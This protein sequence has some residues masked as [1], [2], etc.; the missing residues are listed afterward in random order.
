MLDKQGAGR[1]WLALIAASIAAAS[2]AVV[3]A[4]PPVSAHTPPPNDGFR[5]AT[6][7][8]PP[9][10][11]PGP[12]APVDKQEAAARAQRAKQEQD[13]LDA[14]RTHAAQ[15]PPPLAE[16]AG[17]QVSPAVAKLLGPGLGLPVGS[18]LLTGLRPDPTGG[19]LRAR[20]GTGPQLT[21]AV[22]AGVRP[23]SFP[24]S[25]LVVDPASDTLTLTAS[26]EQAAV[27]VR[28]AHA[29]KTTLTDEHDL[30][31]QVTLS[32]AVLGATV[33]LSGQLTYSGGAPGVSLTGTLADPVVL[34]R[35]VAVLDKGAQVGL[36]STELRLS[37]TADL[38]PAKRQVRVGVD[39]RVSG[40]DSWSLGVVGAA[41]AAAPVP[42]LT[43][44]GTVTG[45]VT[46]GPGGVE[47]DVR[48]PQSGAWR[49]L[50][51]VTVTGGTVRLGNTPARDGSL[52]APGTGPTT[53][54]LAVS[55][56]VA[57]TA[58]RA[59]AVGSRGTVAI[60]LATGAGALSARHDGTFELSPAP[61]RV[62]L[63]AAR[64]GGRLT[65]A[66]AAISGSVDGTG[67]LTITPAG[68]AE[69]PADASLHVSAAGALI[70][71]FP[72]DAAALGLGRRGTPVT[73]YWSAAAGASGFTGPAGAAPDL[74]AG[75]SA[76]APH[77]GT[78][79]HAAAKTE[80]ATTGKTQTAL[81]EA[82]DEPA[83][84][85]SY[86]LSPGAFDLI[87]EKLGIPLDSPT[88]SGDESG[89]TLTI[90]VGAPGRLPVN[91]PSG[92]PNPVFGATTIT[93]DESSNTVT[94]AASATGSVTG[95]LQVTIRNAGTTTLSDGADLTATLTLGNVPFI[96]GATVTLTGALTY[97]GGSLGAS[98]TGTLAAALP[99][100]GGAVTLQP[101]SAV[102]IG[103]DT[104]L[105]VTGTALVGIGQDTFSVSVSGS[106]A[107]LTNWSLSVT[108]TPGQSWQP[109]SGVTLYPS[110]T[111]SLSKQGGTV[112]F[113]V[114][115]ASVVSWSPG[116]GATLSVTGFELSNLP[117]PAT[118]SCPKTGTGDVWLDLRGSFSYT[119]SG[120][121]PLTAD[122]C[123]DLTNRSFKIKTTAPGTLLPGNPVYNLGNA[124]LT[125]SG[126]LSGTFTVTGSAD[127]TVHAPAGPVTALSA[128]V[129]F[130]TDG[131]LVG[132]TVPDLSKFSSSLSG[133]G[134]VYV[135]TKSIAGFRPAD[136]GLTG[137]PF[138]ATVPL[139]AGVNLA[140]SY[141]VA[142]LPSDVT[143]A[144]N[145]VHA[146]IPSGTKIL[147]VA[148]VSTAGIS[149]TLDVNFGTDAGGAK[150]F[151]QNGSAF[152]IDDVSLTIT[153]GGGTRVTLAGAGY[154][155]LPAMWSGGAASQ[156]GVTVS[157]ALDLD[158][159][160]PIIS[161][162]LNNWV[163]A[164]GV[165][166][167]SIKSLAGS[168]GISENPSVSFTADQ[169]T[170]PS[171]WPQAI[172]LAAGARISLNATISLTQPL[173]SFA[174]DPPA[175][176]GVALTPLAVGYAGQ[177]AAGIPLTPAQQSVVNSLQIKQAS[178]F[179][180]P[181]GGT[182]AAGVYISPGLAVKFDATVDNVP[183]KVL[184]SVG[185]TP[186][187]LFV[188]VSV[189]GYSIGPVTLASTRFLMNLSPTQIQFG[190]SGGFSYGSSSFNL[191]VDLAFGSTA[192]GASITA[193]VRA[194]VPSFLQLNASLQGSVSGDGS[195]AQLAASA[196]GGI[197]FNGHQFGTMRFQ[198]YL[199]GGGLSW[200]DTTDSVTT[201]VGYFISYGASIQSM[202]T[203][204]H[205]LGY[206]Q[207]DLFN[208]LGGLGYYSNVLLSQLE[209]VFNPFSTVYYDI[210]TYT[211]SG[212]LLVL[213]VTNASQTPDTKVV[214][215]TWNSGYN[216]DWA[217][218]PSPYYA[219]WYEVVNRNSGQ[220]LSDFGNSLSAGSPL[221]QYPCFGGTDQLW[222]FGYIALNTTYVVTNG[223]SGY[224]MDVQSAYAWPGG[225]MDQWP[226]N[227][228]RNQQ[229][230]LTNSTK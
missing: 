104:G 226:Y 161:L 8:R 79:L 109:V 179:M 72:T 118:V 113:D 17:Y 47:Y 63:G 90:V 80:L 61:G 167:M 156:T 204:M 49:L 99:M 95:T 16:T 176:G 180:S 214:T 123:L 27:T 223:R 81:A 194:G 141:T 36:T 205:D 82:G 191:R 43:L 152:Y 130:G 48:A 42:G 138:P 56:D 131:V 211:S 198:L 84:G 125:V 92:V 78:L 142:G 85:T 100:A 216:Q 225:A 89:H 74:P 29:S 215:W 32:V 132:V 120:M 96:E 33:A 220:C 69:V 111:A 40:G 208:A 105:S 62:T 163:N 222:Y 7:P 37:G 136:Y 202:M 146:S 193:E 112:G 58:G 77:A 140:Y 206:Q 23:P 197:L 210:W 24:D 25:T 50:P 64:F 195:G 147:A 169:V 45:T 137:G 55:G 117:P 93:V 38:G 162:G 229:F 107:S 68:G 219:G 173:L 66:D 170:L 28:V 158:T 228:G 181:F 174:I 200:S 9:L 165:P 67:L 110:F 83:D 164:F 183:V 143:S 189:G 213:D 190:F 157:A 188:N 103:T 12:V 135:S 54:W 21:F 160:S 73:G 3:A 187:S 129:S 184:G 41:P 178:F 151:D 116:A 59:G 30:T 86:T 115:S 5:T 150:L 88:V 221:V 192:N 159:A 76:T 185:V 87:D 15:Q 230:W 98:L 4:G 133:S 75:V 144:L 172:G 65:V 22:P 53:P 10:A 201:L 52:A 39:G 207:Y 34:Q 13:A 217:F 97:S 122:G 153:V 60:N 148:Q 209:S 186:P 20:F 94:L 227:G 106:L 177:I 119:P 1:R 196:Y 171:G 71:Q 126:S 182:T 91:L 139:Q 218:I 44:G 2:V 31:S 35:D 134:A 224:V 203:T 175:P 155:K 145:S 57:V 108:T 128:A 51:G 46:R 11:P 199:P 18:P 26:A 154:L 102:S 166:G 212:Q 101:G 124:A 168:I 149:A 127:L 114:S 121:S 14:V 19:T 6:D 70:A